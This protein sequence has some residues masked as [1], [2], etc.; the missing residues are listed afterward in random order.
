MEHMTEV[1]PEPVP[2][3]DIY[4]SLR[5]TPPGIPS[6]YFYDD[7]GSQLFDA[8]TGLPEYYLTRVEEELL[9]RVSPGIAE[10]VPTKRLT[11]L[12]AGMARKT[13]LLIQAL[14]AR[15]GSLHFSPLD[16]SH[17]AL[18]EAEKTVGR[19][20]PG[21]KVE[22]IRC[23]YT[24][25]LEA[26][27]L[28]PGSLTLFLGSTIGNFTDSQGIALLRRLRDRLHA[29]DHLLLGV[30]LVKPV[31]IL[32]AAYNDSRGITAEFNRNILRVVNRKAGGNFRL[33]D[34]Q[35]LAF[36]NSRD[37]QMEMHLV[38]RR[39]VTVRLESFDLDL[40][41]K[42]GDAIK[43][44]I[45]RKFTRESCRNLLEAGGFVVT[46]WFTADQEYFGLALARAV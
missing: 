31:K 46:D 11:E 20:F 34:F 39:N 35:H 28:E 23:D 25:S 19:E 41:L 32:E 30:D 13:R 14:V 6:K 27:T 45:S 18:E 40:Q 37:S 36:F 21:V 2:P 4:R 16:I 33:D 15:N 10:M 43:T 42:E 29:G 17:Y 24:R 12:G 1:P 5:E 38:A 26:L 7:R 44:E 3:E 9:E 8:I 22:G